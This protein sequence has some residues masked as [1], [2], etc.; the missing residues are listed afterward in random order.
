MATRLCAWPAAETRMGAAA[1]CVCV[2]ARAPAHTRTSWRGRCDP[3]HT[4]HRDGACRALLLLCSCGCARVA[5]APSHPAARSR[6]RASVGAVAPAAVVC[7]RARV[8]AQERASERVRVRHTPPCIARRGRTVRIAHSYACA[9]VLVWQAS[10]QLS[11][12][13]ASMPPQSVGRRNRKHVRRLRLPCE[14]AVRLAL[15]CA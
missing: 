2:R 3:G 11:H 4:A 6:R 13:R 8:R 14:L 12:T 10:H 5:R 9:H 7:V 1:L 15:L